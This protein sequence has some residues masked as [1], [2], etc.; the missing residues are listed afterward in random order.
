VLPGINGLL[1]ISQLKAA[2][3]SETRSRDLVFTVGKKEG[4]DGHLI[5]GQGAGLV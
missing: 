4:A 1:C 3:G 5:A 2:L